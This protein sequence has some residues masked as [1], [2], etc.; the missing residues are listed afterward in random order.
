MLYVNDLQ[1]EVFQIRT[2]TQANCNIFILL[3]MLSLPSTLMP[4]KTV[5]AKMVEFARE[6]KVIT[7]A[8]ALTVPK[9][10]DS[11]EV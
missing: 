9:M 5:H 3:Q 6:T 4:A 2:Y 11:M 7:L 10:A 8:N 1:G